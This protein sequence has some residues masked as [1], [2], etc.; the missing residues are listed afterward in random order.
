M[1]STITIQNK[2]EYYVPTISRSANVVANPLLFQNAKQK[3]EGYETRR[4]F[5]MPFTFK[6]LINKANNFFT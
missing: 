4:L 1:R 2:S 5:K 3:R 6:K